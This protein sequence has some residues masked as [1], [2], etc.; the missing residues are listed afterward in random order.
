MDSGSSNFKIDEQDPDAVLGRGLG[1]GKGVLIDAGLHNMYVHTIR[2]AKH[3]LYIENQFFTGMPHWPWHL[4]FLLWFDFGM[5][6]KH[7]VIAVCARLY[8]VGSSV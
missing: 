5:C 3:F 2:R 8:T 7:Q 1:R 4:C 6:K